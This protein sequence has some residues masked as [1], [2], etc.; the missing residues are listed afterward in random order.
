[1]ERWCKHENNYPRSLCGVETCVEILFLT[2]S[3]NHAR[4]VIPALDVTG[5]AWLLK[6]RLSGI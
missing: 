2:P 4:A 5:L 3:V 1:M 6:I